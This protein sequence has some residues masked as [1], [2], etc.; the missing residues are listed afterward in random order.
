MHP[1]GYTLGSVR[2]WLS[3]ATGSGMELGNKKPNITASM[4]HACP[5]KGEGGICML[6]AAVSYLD[7]AVEGWTW[8]G[9]CSCGMIAKTSKTRCLT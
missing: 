6:T 9:W 1:A 7:T 3:M 8:R 4:V 2:H 5:E